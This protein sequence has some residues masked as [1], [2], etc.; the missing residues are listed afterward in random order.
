MTLRL[1]PEV[2]DAVDMVSG[3]N[4]HPRVIEPGMLVI[5]DLQSIIVQNSMSIDNVVQIVF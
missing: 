1:V 2:V 3:F 5:S 4:I